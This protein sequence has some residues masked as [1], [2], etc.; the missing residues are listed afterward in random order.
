MDLKIATLFLKI[1]ATS[2]NVFKHLVVSNE[3]F[4]F[5]HSYF[6]NRVMPCNRVNCAE[7]L[8]RLALKNDLPGVQ[9]FL[10]KRDRTVP[11][12]IFITI[13]FSPLPRPIINYL[14][15]PKETTD[16]GE[17]ILKGALEHEQLSFA[18]LIASREYPEQR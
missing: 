16:I 5:S 14:N 7:C 11:M 12:E 17:Y 3:I 2:W 10:C 15:V 1:E 9:R 18:A 4:Q 8:T 13:P 6:P